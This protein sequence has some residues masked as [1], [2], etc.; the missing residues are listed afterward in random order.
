MQAIILAAG[1]G[2][3]LGVLTR[4]NTKC[5]VQVN[6]VTLISRLLSQIEARNFSRVVIVTG[7][8]E[9]NLKSHIA[10]LSLKTPIEYISNPTY[11]T[12]N[13][14]YSLYLAA[15]QLAEDETILFE[16]D[17]IFEDR[18]LD[19]LINDPSPSLALVAQF[20]SWMDGTCVV[21]DDEGRIERFVSS[22]EFNYN[23]SDRYY[24]TVNIYKFSREFS[25]SHYI[26]FLS[27]YRQAL[28][29]NEYYEQ[30]LKVVA[31]LE[32]PE[33]RALKL[34]D[35]LW[36][37][38]DD[39]QDLDIAESLFAKGEERLSKLE[40]CYGGYWRYN[41][42]VD[43]CYLVNPYFP[44]PRLMAE[45][46][47]NF[48]RLLTD[49]PSGMQVNSLLAAKLFSLDRSQ[50]MAG[51]GAA[52]LINV[53]SSELQGKIGLT[54]PTFE[55][56][57]NRFTPERCETW[58]PSNRDF[59]YSVTD[60]QRHFSQTDITS[61]LLINPD[62][63]SGNMI[64]KEELL[65]LVRWSGERGIRLVVD[66]SFVDFAGGAN[67]HS[68]LN[69]ELLNAYPHLV[70]IKSISKSYGVP[71]L[72][73]GIL[74]SG[75]R[76][77]IERLKKKVSIWNINSFGEF[78]LQIIGKYSKVYHHACAQLAAERDWLFAALNSIDFLRALPSCANYL[79]CEVKAP[80]SARQLVVEL[81]EQSNLLIKDCSQKSGFSGKEYV[82]IAVKSRKENQLLLL[83]LQ[84]MARKG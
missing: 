46:K 78:F 54:L 7:Y 55:E 29:D 61:L 51:N 5:M 35:E 73:L 1:M 83:A 50:I 37:E 38:I 23:E 8:K 77:L 24:K 16:S 53:L 74:A 49:Y 48:D 44:P 71:G 28:G 31:S 84:S 45:L 76:E 56:Y 19:R 58:I 62:N 12:T 39:A 63:P 41:S 34:G 6:G 10:S 70:V 65:E 59:T 15:E 60:L 14:I 43:F 32:N 22:Q 82:R 42:L 68:L 69:K 36:Y 52:E 21:V 66:E 67:D 64:L 75:D 81:L 27:A 17:L 25:R 30:V 40:S 4:E 33:I 47:A 2:K 72:R 11:D 26:P 9:E 20:Q 80:W 18:L 13:N 79:L 3:R 57:L